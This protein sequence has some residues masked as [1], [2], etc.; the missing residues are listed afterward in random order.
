M[1]KHPDFVDYEQLLKNLL[2]FKAELIGQLNNHV[3][4]QNTQEML[5]RLNECIYKNN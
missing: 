4:G 1:E 5:A 2:K 3:L